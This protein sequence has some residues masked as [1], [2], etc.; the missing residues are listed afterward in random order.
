LERIGLPTRPSL[1]HS[2]FF[3]TTGFLPSV[4]DDTKRTLRLDF[5][6][7]QKKRRTMEEDTDANESE[8]AT[9]RVSALHTC[10]YFY[11][12]VTRLSVFKL[13]EALQAATRSA[14]QLG[15]SH[16][17]LYIHSLGGDAFAGMSAYDHIFKNSLPVI[18]IADG[19]VASAASL[20]LLAGARRLAMPHSFVL[21]HQVSL[22]GFEGKFADLQDE[23][24]N[25]T[26]LM[27]AMRD[28]YKTRTR[29]KKKELNRALKN[30]ITLSS[31]EC[32]ELGFVDALVTHDELQL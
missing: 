7:K 8:D 25:S 14:M 6:Q 11:S 29:M 15:V 17:T 12:E 5:M 30:E 26:A 19:I 20:F 24:K 18:T 21:I 2:F 22:S 1:C 10:V 28:I 23:V 3:G 9:S 27:K 32:V 13:I 16:V 31:C 4:S